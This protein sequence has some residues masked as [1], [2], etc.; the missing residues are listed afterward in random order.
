MSFLYWI[1]RKSSTQAK[2][3]TLGDKT[4]TVSFSEILLHDFELAS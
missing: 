3:V 2:V 4:A 1:T